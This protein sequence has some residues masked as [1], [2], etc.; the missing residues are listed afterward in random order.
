MI[1]NREL[2]RIVFSGAEETRILQDP[3][4]SD[5][6]IDTTANPFFY[7]G[8]FGKFAF[9]HFNFATAATSAVTLT[10]EYWDGTAWAA[11]DD[12]VDQTN[13]FR[14]SGF[15]SWV[16]Q[17]DWKTTTVTPIDDTELYW[18]RMT[19]AGSDTISLRS[20]LNVF[21][22]DTLLSVYWPEI[23]SDT[24][25]LPPG[26]TSYLTQH[27]AAKDLVVR[28]LKERKA[29]TEKDEIIDPNPFSVAAVHAVAMILMAPT[30]Q[31]PDFVNRAERMFKDEIQD[32]AKGLDTNRDG[33]VSDAERR[34]LDFSEVVRR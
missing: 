21:S 29:I 11:V 12:V 2:T 4:G 14:Q 24:R 18:I 3:E 33:V 30:E 13:G 32:L 22:D 9:R 17:D 16:N 27:K 25:N 34:D 28:K 8:F 19:L 20:V 31:E 10:I 6:S 23:V 7:M 26:Q 5:L 1:I 15:V